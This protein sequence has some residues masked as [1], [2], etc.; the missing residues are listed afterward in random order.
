MGGEVR[1]AA[2]RRGRLAE[3]FAVLL[4]RAKGYRILARNWKCRAGEIDI[5][6]QRGDLVVAVEVKRRDDL[7]MAAEAILLR[8][9][10]RILEAI[11]V[12][13]SARPD[14]HSCSVRFDAVLVAPGRLPHHLRDAWRP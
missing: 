4:L 1:R 3:S 8:Q 9:R 13:R 7:A 10:H 5:V 2:F 14:L 11:E 6:A 12:F